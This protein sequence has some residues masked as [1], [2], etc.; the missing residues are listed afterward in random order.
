M[1][2]IPWPLWLYVLDHY[3][4]GRSYTTFF[5]SLPHDFLQ[6]LNIVYFSNDSK[7]VWR[8]GWKTTPKQYILTTVL[9]CSGRV[10]LLVPFG[11]QPWAGSAGV[12]ALSCWYKNCW[13]SSGEPCWWSKDSSWPFTPLLLPTQGLLLPCFS[14]HLRYFTESNSVCI[15]ILLCTLATKA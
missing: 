10:L 14:H 13:V 7:V 6:N 2:T 9:D 11:D 5:H 4:P 12:Y 3:L 15:L 1:L 8:I